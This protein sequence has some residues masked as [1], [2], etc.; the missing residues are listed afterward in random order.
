MIK[1]CDISED[2]MILK[3]FG[4]TQKAYDS[5]GSEQR[6]VLFRIIFE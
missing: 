2:R 5:T 3:A 6:V 4:G 1:N